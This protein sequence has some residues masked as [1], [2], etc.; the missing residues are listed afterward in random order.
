MSQ[1]AAALDH[2]ALHYPH[3]PRQI[4]IKVLLH[5]AASVDI[6]MESR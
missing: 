3:E 1:M 5:M 4:K 2:I 6:A